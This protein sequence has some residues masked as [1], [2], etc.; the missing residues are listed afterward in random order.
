MFY[1]GTVTV[2]TL[3]VM[4]SSL[5]HHWLSW[6]LQQ[7]CFTW[8]T[9]FTMRW[10]SFAV[11]VC[12]SYERGLIPFYNIMLQCLRMSTNCNRPCNRHLQYVTGPAKIDHVSTKKLLIFSVFAV[13]YLNNYLYYCNKI[14]I[15]TAKF[16]GL[17]SAA[18]VNGIA[19][20]E[21]KILAKI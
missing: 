17:S 14:F 10:G 11:H 21:R 20:S 18:Y 15:T 13:S 12:R 4:A 16:N 5:N 3:V 1:K 9:T 8:A 7:K 2:T 19:N 6:V